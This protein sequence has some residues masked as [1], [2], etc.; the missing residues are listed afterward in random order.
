MQRCRSGRTSTIG[1]RVM[2]TA[3]MGSNPILCATTRKHK[4]KQLVFFFK[5][6]KGCPSLGFLVSPSNPLCLALWGPHLLCSAF[7]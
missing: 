4:F 1:N 5:N 2:L 6:T 3:S 7:P